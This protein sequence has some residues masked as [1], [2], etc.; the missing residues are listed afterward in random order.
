FYDAS[1]N[2]TAEYEV[3]A[4]PLRQSIMGVNRANLLA[5]WT[6]G[7]VYGLIDPATDDVG[8]IASAIAAAGPY[9]ISGYSG[10]GFRPDDYSGSLS[11]PVALS[12]D[13]TGL[14]SAE[15][16]IERMTDADVFSFSSSGVRQQLIVAPDWP[17]PLD[18][19]VEV[20]DSSDRLIY[21]SDK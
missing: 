18:A 12:T 2:Q 16:V 1:G 15:G 8:I 20:Y 11:T 4:D 19:K 10:D 7:L 13:S 6:T 21:A 3:T 17:S 5:K 14:Q 9:A